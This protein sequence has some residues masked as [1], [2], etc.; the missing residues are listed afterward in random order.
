MQ[1]LLAMKTE[2][3]KLDE[4]R[5]RKTISF[6]SVNV[7][8]DFFFVQRTLQDEKHLSLFP[9]R[10]WQNHAKFFSVWQEFLILNYHSACDRLF[11]IK[12]LRTAHKVPILPCRRLAR[13]WVSSAE[14]Y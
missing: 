4:N 9:K 12:K 6:E 1:L 13:F 5:I 7:D 8:S 3:L 10:G 11:L 2:K 14:D